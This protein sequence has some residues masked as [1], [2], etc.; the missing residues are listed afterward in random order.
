MDKFSY[1]VYPFVI[2][3][4]SLYISVVYNLIKGGIQLRILSGPQEQFVC[5][6]TRDRVTNSSGVH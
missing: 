4:Y 6:G 2:L 5:L 1:D 3:R